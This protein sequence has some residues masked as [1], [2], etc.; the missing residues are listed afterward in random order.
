MSPPVHLFFPFVP[1][2]HCFLVAAVVS[3]KC[4][5]C[6]RECLSGCNFTPPNFFC[7]VVFSFS[8]AV[9]EELVPRPGCPHPVCWLLSG[10]WGS[11]PKGPGGVFLCLLLGS[12]KP[13]PARYITLLIPDCW[14]QALSTHFC[15]F[16]S[17][18]C[19]F[20]YAVCSLFE[21]W[22]FSENCCLHL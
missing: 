4:S 12:E 11:L 1:S 22:R 6:E 16:S 3:H 21:C 13:P 10:P 18:E 15:L 8:A 20:F 14:T 19:S 2:P 7:F 5:S 9:S 17:C